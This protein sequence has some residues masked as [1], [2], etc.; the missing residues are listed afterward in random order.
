MDRGEEYNVDE[1]GKKKGRSGFNYAD[2][3]EGWS[4]Q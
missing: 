1:E 4:K 2:P 3:S